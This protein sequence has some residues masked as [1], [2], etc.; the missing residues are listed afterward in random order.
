MRAG[1]AETQIESIAQ[2][3]DEL[4]MN[5]LYDAPVDA[6]GARLF[7]GVSVKRRIT[8]R[9]DREVAVEYAFDGARFAVAVR[10]AFGRLE[11]GT[12]LRHLYKGLHASDKVE[13]KAGGAGLGL[14]LMA[15]TASALSFTVRPGGLCEA[16][17]LFERTGRTGAVELDFVQQAAAGTP[18]AARA[19][20]TR[21]ARSARIHRG[22]RALL[23]AAFVAAA[24]LAPPFPTSSRVAL[25]LSPANARVVVDGRPVAA[26]RD[27]IEI[28]LARTR[29][30]VVSSEGHAPVEL[31]V[32][33]GVAS[34][35]IPVALA[36]VPTVSL[37]STPSDAAVTVDGVAIGSTPLT[38][39]TLAPGTHV[40]LAF[41]KPGY[42]HATAQ[43]TV[44]ARG[45]HS[46]HVQPL[47]RADELVRV[48]VT[49]TPSGAEIVAEGQPRPRDHTYTPA[50]V[51]VEAD[52][53]ARF[54]LSMRGYAPRVVQVLPKRGEDGVTADATLVKDA[55]KP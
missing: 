33:G 8:M 48:R 45:Q 12:V 43:L 46:E 49:S 52:R 29:H 31:A 18:N 26:A 23:G 41:D 42:Q 6:R 3:V 35:S 22:A 11:R 19:M 16:V 37:D 21:E 36:E 40:A 14:Y 5:A 50:D 7:E 44:P 55:A 17:C 39:T 30:L 1:L 51:F 4:V 9:T 54:T 32:R 25:E 2:C 15:S 24:V 34:R 27:G 10:D 20:L 38:I 47:A 28:P 53:P 13:S